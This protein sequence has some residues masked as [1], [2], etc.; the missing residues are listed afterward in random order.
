LLFIVGISLYITFSD[1][2]SLIVSFFGF[3]MILPFSVM[4]L[5]VKQK[6]SLLL[7]TIA[8]AIAGLI[9]IG[10]TYSTGNIFNVMTKS[11]II[12]FIGFQW[13]S[14][15]MLIKESN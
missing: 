3:T 4:L 9:A 15:L 1:K 6:N 5:P 2:L 13:I 8:M 12:G 7:F 11:Y 14:N 10:M